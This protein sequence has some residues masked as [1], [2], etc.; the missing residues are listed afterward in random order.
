M[1][2]GTKRGHPLWWALVMFGLV[3]AG[4]GGS[5][6]SSG[7]DDNDNGDP[8][9]LDE[10]RE[11]TAA[12]GDSA[13]VLDW[14]EAQ[15]ALW[16]TIYYST[17]PEVTRSMPG[18]EVVD[19]VDGPPFTVEGLE[20]DQVYF[21]LVS[22]SNNERESGVSNRASAAPGPLVYGDFVEL[23]ERTD[24]P[25][26]FRSVALP[27]TLYQY[28]DVCFAF[29]QRGTDSHAW[30]VDDVRY[31]HL[32]MDNPSGI[33]VLMSDFSSEEFPPDDWN[34]YQFGAEPERQWA[35]STEF[36]VSSPASA[37]YPDIGATFADD[38]WLVTTEVSLM[39]EPELRFHEM[40]QFGG[41]QD[42]NYSGVFISNAS[43]DPTPVPNTRLHDGGSFVT[44]EGEGADGADISRV[45]DD[46]GY[47]TFGF[48]LYLSA[49][50]QARL[51]DRFIVPEGSQWQ[52][53]SIEVLA[54]VSDNGAGFEPGNITSRLRILQGDLLDSVEGHDELY[55]SN[56]D[57]TIRLLDWTGAYR[58]RANNLESDDNPIMALTF[59]VPVVLPAGEYWLELRI[60]AGDAN[61]FAVPVTP[62]SSDA[63]GTALQLTDVISGWETMRDGGNDNQMSLPLRIYGQTL[64]A[65]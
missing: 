19:D 45:A 55:D 8:V 3:L 35:R 17:D 61:T 46:L 27:L 47:E 4:C 29:S 34:R 7:N 51:A 53:R 10:P 39:E 42:D 56:G 15:G 65:D 33:E 36:S 22:A 52:V 9:R 20:N 25:S 50:P 14:S 59:S 31:H 41:F 11:L 48:P 2:I 6:G 38:G 21:F 58:V 12:G 26:S 16:Y 18:V 1:R 24:L 28:Q 23:S 30:Y 49:A 5:S 44:S 57:S 13:V 63:G 32:T 54:F 64:S 62:T 37:H 40:A 60:N 43:C